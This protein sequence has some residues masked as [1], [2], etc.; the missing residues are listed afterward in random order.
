MFKVINGMA[1]EFMNDIFVKNEN[2]LTDNV[3][4]NTRSQ[5]S[6][7]KPSNPRKTNYGLESLMYFGPKN[8]GNDTNRSKGHFIFVRI[9]NAN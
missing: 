4:S 9:Q 1:P 6:F 3:S 8:M 5:S 2:I 7:Y